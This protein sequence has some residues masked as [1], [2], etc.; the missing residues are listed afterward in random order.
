M[1]VTMAQRRSVRCAAR[2][3]GRGSRAASR[4]LG[5]TQGA[6]LEMQIMLLCRFADVDHL[7]NTVSLDAV[8]TSFGTTCTAEQPV[9]ITATL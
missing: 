6:D 5:T 4:C 8:F 2:E 1:L 9:P 7:W 3:A